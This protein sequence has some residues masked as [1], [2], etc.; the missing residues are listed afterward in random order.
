MK[1]RSNFHIDDKDKEANLNRTNKRNNIW[2][3]KKAKRHQS[4]HYQLKR[5]S[6]ENS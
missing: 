2:Y 1:Y 3:K 5:N 4:K 6:R